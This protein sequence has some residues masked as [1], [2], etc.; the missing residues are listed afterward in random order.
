[1]VSN[2]D[3]YELTIKVKMVT[4]YNEIIMYD[5]YS[6]WVGDYINEDYNK[7]ECRGLTSAKTIFI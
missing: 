1:M 4:A 5:K 3:K 6:T 2:T 7:G